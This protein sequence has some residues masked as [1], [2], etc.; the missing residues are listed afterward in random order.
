MR[1]PPRIVF[2]DIWPCID[3]GRYPA[4]RVVGE[5]LTVGGRIYADGHDRLRCA[6]AFQPPGER[7]WS[8]VPMVATN[9][10]LDRWCG[11]FVP[12][13]TGVYRYRLAAWIDHLGTWADAVQRKLAAG[14]EIGADLLV[15][16]ELLVGLANRLPRADREVA[17]DIAAQLRAGETAPVWDGRLEPLIAAGLSLKDAVTSRPVLEVLVEK[18]QALFSAWYELF[19]RS[20]S[21]APGQ[22]GTF[23]DV[24]AQLDYVVGMGFD[25][26]YLPPI[27]PI[28]VTARKGRN[29]RE[30]AAPGDP[31]SPW[32]IGSSEGG[33]TA[34]H[35]DLGTLDEFRSLVRAA[36]EQG[37]A[38]ALDIAFQC[39]P[40][41][42]WV[43]EHPEWFRHRPDGTI[44]YAE[45]PPKKYQDIYPLNFETES[46]Q[47][48]WDALLGVFLFW[49]DQGISVFRV[50]NP[51]TKPFPFWE[52]V[53]AEVRA[54]EPDAIFLSEAFTR[55]AVMHRLAKIGFTLSY[56]YFPWRQSK[57]EIIDYFTE[58][59]TP[60]SV[61]YFRPS[62]WPNT[63][64][65]LTRQLW[66]APRELFAIRYALAG[67][68][69]PSLGI[70]GPAFELCENRD[71]GNGKEEYL[72]SEKYEIRTWDR[73]DP[74][75]LAE[76]IGE[77]NAIR[78]DQLALH[79]LRTLRFHQV[80][81]DAL[82]VFSKAPHSGPSV[83]PARP[84]Q[85]TVLCVVTLDPHWT[86]GGWVDLDL[87][88]LGV[89]PGR[90][91]TVHDLVSDR[92]FIWSGARN[93]VEL[94]PAEQVCHI[95]R[96][97]QGN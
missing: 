93:Y 11:E 60:P 12:D 70:Y 8:L 76:F 16:A 67:T 83:D 97:T 14:V 90:E 25:V 72:N 23:K 92:S 27:H 86:Q 85:A 44:H 20:W 80:D 24:E 4:K 45:N 78:R 77:I 81:N 48:L 89:D 40:D 94:R 66:G 28:G 62:S 13:R 52:W 87:G 64:D 26:L 59:S 22:H 53:I 17:R 56:D 29:N 32:A 95:F 50:D 63:P 18:E 55:P 82:V 3:G 61:D 96:V 46:W 7:K 30:R 21:L 42:P 1:V 65:I 9:P 35:P 91:F 47:E 73:D 43:T 58:L 19:P 10:G 74:N 71:A 2:E 69:T 31:G 5:P 49:V 88:A 39:S 75:S 54:R 34:V 6:L 51:H 15:G 38:I 68:L 57:Q 33:H 79:T 84:A 41:H 36:K 37:L